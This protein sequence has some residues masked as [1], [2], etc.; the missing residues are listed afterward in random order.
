MRTVIQIWQ[1]TLAP[2]GLFVASLVSSSSF[3]ASAPNIT[4]QPQS[5]NVIAG[6]NAV[7][8]VTATGSPTP[9]YQWSVNGTNLV[10]G[11]HIA[12]SKSATLTVSN[13][14]IADSGNYRVV[15]T[16]SHGSATSSNALLTVVFPPGITTQPVDQAVTWG[17]P[18]VFTG[19]ASGTPT[20]NFR[21][22]KDGVNLTDGNGITGA[23]TA[24]LTISAAQPTNAGQY[25]LTVTN[26]YG[27]ALTTNATL[28][29]SPL[30]AWGNGDGDTNAP[31]AAT[32]LVAFDT[33]WQHSLALRGDG[34]VIAWGPDFYGETVVPA[35][36][37][38]VV[39]VTA[40]NYYS[41]ALREDGSLVI[42]GHTSFGE[43]NVP[44]DA[45]NLVAITAGGFSSVGLREDGTLVPWGNSTYGQAPIPAFAS[46]IVAVASGTFHTLAL[47]A[48][49]SVV[50]W[51]DNLF[52]QINVPPTATNVIAIAAGR[53]HNLALRADG[54]VIAWGYND[55]GQATVPPNATNVTAIAAGG[56]HSEALRADGTIVGW[57]QD[58]N[59]QT[60][61]P[62]LPA[63]AVLLEAG[64]YHS[65]VLLRDPRM[66][67]PPR[68]WKQPASRS[69]IIP[70]NTVIFRASV[71]G[72][73]PVRYQWL[74]D[75]S[76]L[77]GETNVWLALSAVQYGQ[78]GGYQFVATNGF[79]AV[80]SA[81]ANLSILQPPQVTQDVQSQTVVA[82]T[83]V[84]LSVAAI[85]SAPLHYQWSFNS[86]LI[87]D[88]GGISGS[89]TP[90]L[91]I[92]SAQRNDSGVYSVM[93]TN[94]AGT[95]YSAAELNV[96]P[97]PEF[98]QQPQSV[99][100]VSG[101]SVILA[102]YSSYAQNYQWFFN[103]AP[104]TDS[105][106][107]TGTS[108]DSLWIHTLQ[109]NDSGNYWVVATNIAGATTSSVATVTVLFLPPA[110]GSPPAS[111]VKALCDD[112]T[113][114]SPAAGSLPI[115]Y[116][117]FFEG[118]P[119][120]DGNRV[121]GATNYVLN[122]TALQTNDAGNYWLVA[123]NEVGVVTGAVATLTVVVPP[124]F[125]LQP[126]N[127][128]WVAGLNGSF[129]VAATG[130]E[131]LSYQWYHGATQL[132]DGA[133]LSGTTASTLSV[134]NV[135]TSDA[136]NYT[137]VVTNLAGSVTSAAATVTVIV[138]PTITTQPKGR[139]AP[140]GLPTI[141]NA[142]ATGT[143][144]LSYQ[145]QFNGTNIPGATA[146]NY[147][148]SSLTAN[149]FGAYQLIV[150]NVAGAI[151]SSV[152]MLTFGPVA[153]WGDN[154][155]GQGLPPP[156][157][158]N[159]VALA[160]SSSF[161]L[162]LKSDGTVVAW[163]S[164]V[165]T[166]VPANLS[167]VVAIAAGATFGLGVRSDGTVAAWGSGTPT[168]VPATVSNIVLTSGSFSHALGLRT[169]GTLVEWGTS[170]SKTPIPTG[171]T[172]V[173]S[174]AD[175]SGFAVASRADG[176]VVAW[177]SLS[178]AGLINPNAPTPLS[179]V[180]SVAAGPSHG[181]A[182][183][184][185]GRIFA[186]GSTVAS[187]TS[188]PASLTNAMAIAA[189]SSSDQSPA[190]SLALRSNGLVTGWGA[191]TSGVTNVPSGL[192]NVVAIAAGSSHALALVSDGSPA[193]IRQPVGGTAFSGSQFTL[194]AT[195]ASPTPLTFAWSLNGTNIPN[196]TNS[197]FLISNAQPADA[198]FY[199]LAVTN[200][201]GSALSVPVPIVVVD[202]APLIL[203]IPT[204]RTI[205]FGS[206]LVIEPAVT[207]SQPMQFQWQ[208]GG[209]NISG[210]TIGDLFVANTNVVAGTY[211]LFASNA[212]GFVSSNVT[213]KVL[214]PVVAWGSSSSPTNVPAG[215]S[216]AIAIAAGYYAVGSDIALKADGTVISWNYLGN[217]PV[218]AGLSNVMEIASG[219]TAGNGLAL[220][221][222]GRVT[223]WGNLNTNF[224]T[225]LSNIVSIEMDD[226]GSSYLRADGSVARLT[227]NSITNVAGLTNIVSL[228]SFNYGYIALRADGTLFVDNQSFG[229]VPLSNNVMAVAAGGYRAAQG[230]LLRR[231]GSLVGWGPTN[232]P[233]VGSNCL[234]V[235]A[236]MYNKFAI[237][238]DGTVALVTGIA[239]EI[240][241]NIPAGLTNVSVIDAGEQHVTALLTTR[242]FPPVYLPNA[243]DTTN[244]VVSSKGGSQWFGQTNV[245]HDGSH[246]AQSGP[247]GSGTASSM[248]LWTTG[249]R[250]I[251]FWWKV[252]S[253]TNHDFLTFSA[254]GVVLT[255]I[256]G[257][258]GWQQCTLVTPPGNQILQWTYSKD[259]TGTAGQDA[260]WMDQLAITPVPPS[261]VA[262][263]VGT[264]VLGGANVTFA[265]SAT[266]T[267][268][269]TYRWRKDGNVLSSGPSPSYSL[270]NLTRSNSG[271]YSVVVT[272]IA[273]NTTSSNAAL[274]V[275]VAQ[276]VSAP[277]LQPD[278]TITF[279]SSDVDGGILSSSDLTNF[280]AQ[281]SSNLVDW[282]TLPGTLTLTNGLLQLQDSYVTDAPMRFYRIIETW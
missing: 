232:L 257:E 118:T 188:V 95:V 144:P 133:R 240:T 132:A 279:N 108:D 219:Y 226:S 79:G 13:V 64:A 98:V 119:L 19:S 87:N 276:Q 206:P 275:H 183:K 277:T 59:G 107:I 91:Q 103:N 236:T 78:G 182:L 111:Q 247:L 179:D 271:I 167:N 16:N 140:A 145:W 67:M 151:T 227:F 184:S 237:R 258:T 10:N 128:T 163:G 93:I 262:Q 175:S 197:S 105:S 171:L 205:Y 146:N 60:D 75:G 130:T 113:F 88:G 86:V 180:V 198:G 81:L 102:A 80:T 22:Q 65:A 168:N 135:L 141:F 185:N 25:Q 181:L 17:N 176:S 174:I 242:G 33:S 210:A 252:S 37:T 58:D 42:W 27:F 23:T 26:A 112:V 196:A 40:G 21:W 203:S 211:T 134:S 147:T 48:D 207:G 157:L 150:T 56:Y 214:G 190:Y 68:I 49:R 36:A 54:T 268:P 260:G 251:S 170:G 208:F 270:F 45:T 70:G 116:Q 266:G 44:P 165:G 195:V 224:L 63:Q 18:A 71:L 244:L 38:N 94:V 177:G 72:A 77:P 229:A 209:T 51:G 231:D 35:A 104:M 249:P 7:F 282:V 269:L 223:G 20:L 50:A 161:S 125:T 66:R 46:N 265:V 274:G 4:V 101:A 218:P 82:G 189:G 192:S 5:Q 148:N 122:I 52:G 159:V 96:V 225:G 110:F 267:P 256:S 83:N 12:G 156:G 160:A 246:A 114:S 129:T 136:G 187:V 55:S 280:H 139:S 162:A 2:L 230:L 199:Q 204:N 281:V 117:W 3:A 239:S 143:T 90:T 106:R 100:N 254:G 155:N 243:L 76:A 235:A 142:T 273:G 153:Q 278:G 92:A 32:N 124:A 241:T 149:D 131:P 233:L 259:A 166:N 220:R 57:G 228:T 121:T 216:N 73:L 263:P 28:F 173:T 89:Q 169:E 238:S 15:A 164:T 201:A 47:R 115:S 43:A 11:S 137:V 127:Q 245:T 8:D 152:A 74:R 1:A 221:T 272:N 85:G 123:S 215:A 9:T 126:T 158:S 34:R 6:S 154:R 31:A 213:V 41:V 193:I 97:P 200:A 24:T 172:K 138:P 250:N 191:N 14:T 222:N 30:L 61:T 194:S 29:V 261:I 99:T 255:N 53:E 186:W 120:S 217:I 39:A 69:S 202:S 264:N 84:T 62:P 253:E 178:P 234:G 212:F 248:R 109:T